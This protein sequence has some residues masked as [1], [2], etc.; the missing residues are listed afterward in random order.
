M[1]V[2]ILLTWRL[3]TCDQPD[4]KAGCYASTAFSDIVSWC[5]CCKVTTDLPCEYHT[6][7]LL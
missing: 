2:H 3:I 1:W 5:L 6:L 7:Q 4:T